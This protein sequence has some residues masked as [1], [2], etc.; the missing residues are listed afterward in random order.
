MQ[1]TIPDVA[2][3]NSP[4]RNGSVPIFIDDFDRAAYIVLYLHSISPRT[5]VCL[6][7]SIC[8]YAFG[9]QR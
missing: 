5:F 2:H 7:D 8:E 6:R 9:M 1:D 4:L 3:D